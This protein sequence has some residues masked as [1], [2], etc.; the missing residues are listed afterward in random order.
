VVRE[1]WLARDSLAR[2]RDVAPGRVL[3]DAAIVEAALAQPTSSDELVALPRFG[4]RATRRQAPLW[5]SAVERAHLVP[6]DELPSTQAPT[7]GPPPARSW[8]D[9]NPQAAARL[10]ALRAAVAAI[11]DEHALPTENLLAPDIVRRLAW[12]PPQPADLTAVRHLLETHRARA[13]QVDLTAQPMARA[14]ERLQR[15]GPRAAQPRSQGTEGPN[16]AP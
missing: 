5:W 13:W 14:L 6:E 4:G 2:T 15:S 3:P 10:A 9:R 1:L 16:P 8:G 11:A 12:E 7:D